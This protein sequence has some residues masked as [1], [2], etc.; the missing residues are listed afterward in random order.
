MMTFSK[1]TAK[2]QN[3]DSLKLCYQSFHEKSLQADLAEFQIKEKYKLLKFLPSLGYDAFRQSPIVT[4]SFNSISQRL[5][6]NALNKAKIKSIQEKYRV[7]EI[8]KLQEIEKLYKELLIKKE[9]LKYKKKVFEIEREIFELQS[10]LYATHQSKP[11][12]FLNSKLKFATSELS[13][14]E[15][16]KSIIIAEMELKNF[17]KCQ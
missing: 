17:C 14:I 11:Q 5:E 16:E 13:F 1:M 7:L 3:L 4:F 8:E 2:S 9:V 6:T 10:Q 15:L 12:D